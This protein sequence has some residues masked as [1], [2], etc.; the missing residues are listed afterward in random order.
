MSGSLGCFFNTKQTG[1]AFHHNMS[2]EPFCRQLRKRL[3]HTI[4]DT[5]PDIAERFAPSHRAMNQ[6]LDGTLNAVE[7]TF[8]WGQCQGGS[9]HSVGSDLIFQVIEASEKVFAKS[10]RLN[11]SA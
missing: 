5:C 4:D 1:D 3:N 11:F 2:H 8:D 9:I 7:Q 6:T 10:L